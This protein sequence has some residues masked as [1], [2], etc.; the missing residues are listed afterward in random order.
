MMAGDW[1]GFAYAA[2]LALGGFMGYKRKELVLMLMLM[3]K[4]FLRQRDV[5]GGRPLLRSNLWVRSFQKIAGPSG[6]LDLSCVGRG[7]DV[8]DGAPVPQVREGDARRT[9]GWTQVEYLLSF[10]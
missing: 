1:T 7:T 5:V 3:L 10:L 8:G 9:D 4:V 2:A 6:F